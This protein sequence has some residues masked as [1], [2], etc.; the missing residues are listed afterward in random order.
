M[1]F[2]LVVS[3]QTHKPQ[4]LRVS[5]VE[6]TPAFAAHTASPKCSDVELM[7]LKKKTKPKCTLIQHKPR[8]GKQMCGLKTRTW[9]TGAGSSPVRS[10][11][12]ARQQPLQLWK[13]SGCLF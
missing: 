6:I 10:G 9:L 4:H 11:E 12:G 2:D 7:S 8:S 13:I 1:H 3:L 5:H